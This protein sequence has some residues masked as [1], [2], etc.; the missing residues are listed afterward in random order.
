[1]TGATGATVVSATS[2][3]A[4]ARVPVTMEHGTRSTLV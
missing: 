3:D 2:A 4:Q 1:M